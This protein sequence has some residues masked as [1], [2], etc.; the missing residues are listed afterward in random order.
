MNSIKLTILLV[1]LGIAVC[2]VNICIKDLR[3]AGGQFKTAINKLNNTKNVDTFI[4]DLALSMK[5]LPDVIEDCG[6]KFLADK[7][8]KNMPDNCVDDISKALQIGNKMI[9]ETDNEIAFAFGN[10]NL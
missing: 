7:L 6:D 10:Y 8:R 1:V 4:D 3:L 9:G 5:G 2:D